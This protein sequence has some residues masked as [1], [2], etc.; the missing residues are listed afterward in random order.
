MLLV[1]GV[2]FN[3]SKKPAIIG[4]SLKSHPS[5]PNPSPIP[6]S[7]PSP[8]FF[9]PMAGGL[10]A[11]GGGCQGGGRPKP[12]G[13]SGTFGS[14]SGRGRVGWVRKAGGVDT[15][16]EDVVVRCEDV[17]SFPSWKVWICVWMPVMVACRPRRVSKNCMARATPRKHRPCQKILRLFRGVTHTPVSWCNSPATW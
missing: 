7:P 16:K 4:F 9:R 8:R 1:Q 11:P 3:S 14:R 15:T 5:P 6:P 12:P 13:R 17:F 2:L 10:P